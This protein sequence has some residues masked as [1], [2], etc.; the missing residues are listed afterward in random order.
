[1]YSILVAA[2]DGWYVIEEGGRIDAV[3]FQAVYSRMVTAR[4]MK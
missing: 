3:V 4:S 2:D 1:L